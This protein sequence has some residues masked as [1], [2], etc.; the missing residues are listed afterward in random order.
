MN[1]KHP[2]KTFKNGLVTEESVEVVV[3][4]PLTIFINEEEY[5]TLLCEPSHMEALIFG[6][7]KN[8]FL[9]EDV[10]D[11]IEMVIDKSKGLAYVELD[12]DIVNHI[13]F[14]KRYITAGCASSAMYYDTLDAIKLRSKKNLEYVDVD[15]TFI[16]S[17]Y[18]GLINDLDTTK[19]F[20]CL[21]DSKAFELTHRDSHLINACYKINGEMIT[22]GL[23]YQGKTLLYQVRSQ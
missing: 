15:M 21:K 12:I 5:K 2:I 6:L 17:S 11:V 13:S 18:S 14:R 9:I 23:A 1:N 7:L 16:L 19:S 20:A 22:R 4:F 3:E 10:K 8:D